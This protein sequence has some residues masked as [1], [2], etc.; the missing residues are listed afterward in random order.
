MEST[1]KLP[2]IVARMMHIYFNLRMLAWGHLSMEYNYVDSYVF[3]VSNQNHA[4]VTD[5]NG[6]GMR[7]QYYWFFNTILRGKNVDVSSDPEEDASFPKRLGWA[8]LVPQHVRDVTFLRLVSAP[9]K[10]LRVTR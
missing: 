5:L 8:I 1:A 6:V 9:A 7:L 2:G 3:D 10:I 4:E